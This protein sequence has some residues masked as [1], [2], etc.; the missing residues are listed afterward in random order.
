M[1]FRIKNSKPWENKNVNFKV[2]FLTLDKNNNKKYN[3]IILQGKYVIFKEK[4]RHV[5]QKIKNKLGNKHNNTIIVQKVKHN[6]INDAHLLDLEKIIINTS[7][8][9]ED[10]IPTK[11]YLI[12]SVTLY[13]LD[14]LKHI[15][16][17]E[18]KII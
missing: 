4:Y 8:G 6:I 18:E 12:G 3:S 11:K 5:L 1:L 7:D 9:I 2:N 13:V 14:F 10:M 17:M 16:S 15:Q